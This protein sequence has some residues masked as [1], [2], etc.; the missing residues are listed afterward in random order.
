M[1]ARITDLFDDKVGSPYASD[2]LAN[3]YND[4]EKR[5]QANIP[6]GFMDAKGKKDNSKY[7][8]LVLWFQIMDK[9]KEKKSPVVF[10]CD[11]AKEDWWWVFSG[12]TIGPRP[13]D[14]TKSTA[15]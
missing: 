4:G 15:A 9:A 14:T 2:R 1:L 11:D 12:K 10:I 13:C 8:D 5:Y 3:I 6:P 7:G